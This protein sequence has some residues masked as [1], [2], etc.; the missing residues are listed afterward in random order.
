VFELPAASPLDSPGTSPGASDAR[1]EG[2]EG[3]RATTSAK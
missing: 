2:V 1:G 3:G